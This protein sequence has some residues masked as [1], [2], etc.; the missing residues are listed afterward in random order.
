VRLGLIEEG[1]SVDEDE[2]RIRFK[3]GYV[4]EGAVKYCPIG[5]LLDVAQV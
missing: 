5:Y 1:A 4:G 2:A 3:G